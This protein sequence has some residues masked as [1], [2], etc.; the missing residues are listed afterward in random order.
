MTSLKP[1]DRQVGGDHYKDFIIDPAQFFY[2]NGVPFLE[3]SAMKYI[4]RHRKKNGKQ[5]IEKA[6]HYL[7]LILEY[8]YDDAPQEGGKAPGTPET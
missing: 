2:C 7:E 6:I 8:E 5:D 1:S 3:A 4:L